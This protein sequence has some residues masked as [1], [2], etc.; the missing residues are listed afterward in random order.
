MTKDNN[1]QFKLKIMENTLYDTQN[2]KFF[3]T[4]IKGK[5]N[6]KLEKKMTNLAN[7]CGLEL[8]G[9][10]YNLLTKERDLEYSSLYFIK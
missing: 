4:P 7:S 9:S 8:I 10:G 5:I 1:A 3:Y 6:D 2:I